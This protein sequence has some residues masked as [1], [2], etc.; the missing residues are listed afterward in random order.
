MPENVLWEYDSLG[1][2]IMTCWCC[3][4][5]TVMVKQAAMYVFSP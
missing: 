2:C 5:M 3:S 4:A 1:Q